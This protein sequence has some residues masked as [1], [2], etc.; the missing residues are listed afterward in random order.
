[1]LEEDVIK[2]V[3]ALE[4]SVSRHERVIKQAVDIA[5]AILRSSGRER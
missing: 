5:T 4:E 1:M 3:S 2:R